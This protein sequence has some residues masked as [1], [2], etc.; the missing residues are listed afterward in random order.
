MSMCFPP[1]KSACLVCPGKAVE[2]K[3]H[4]SLNTTEPVLNDKF[5]LVNQ[6][7]RNLPVA[8]RLML[9]DRRINLPL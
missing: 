3:S 8:E 7:V 1:K 2:T 9:S 4:C 6:E 5:V